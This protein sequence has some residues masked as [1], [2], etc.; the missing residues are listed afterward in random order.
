MVRGVES[1]L[2]SVVRNLVSNAVKYTKDGGKVDISLDRIRRGVALTVADTG[3]GMTNETMSQM[4]D[5]GFRADWR[6]T[7]HGNGLGLSLVRSIVYP[8]GGRIK[9]K[10]SPG[11]GSTFDVTLPL[12]M[13]RRSSLAAL[14]R[15]LFSAVF[16]WGVHTTHHFI[17]LYPKRPAHGS[18]T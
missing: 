9:A 18:R 1:D 14:V 16:H 15:R 3:I 4:Y 13:T 8:C 12:D 10:P 5:W 11:N 17:H 6:G 2:D 7:V